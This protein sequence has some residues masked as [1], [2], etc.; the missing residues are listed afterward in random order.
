MNKSIE[1][2]V[3]RHE[4]VISTHEFIGKDGKDYKIKYYN[5]PGAPLDDSRHSLTDP[6]LVSAVEDIR[7]MIEE[8]FPNY[9]DEA[10]EGTLAK[11]DSFSR[12]AFAFSPEGKAVAF[13]LYKI[14][15]METNAG[16]AKVVYIEHAGTL[17]EYRSVGITQEMRNELFR[18]ENPDIICGSSANGVIYIVNK[19][20]AAEKN[21]AFYPTEETTP[22][23]ISRLANQI[24]DALGLR[25]AVLTDNLVRTYNDPTSRGDIEHPLGKS[26]PL[27]ETQ[28]IFYML[29]KPELRDSLLE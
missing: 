18:Q 23:A 12:F 29:I 20:I 6:S 3:P 11:F 8:I 28:H 16:N 9:E 25:N 5:F 15:G 7:K 14:S 21:M 26:L 1:T 17:P 4:P 2:G 22:I 27:K 24:H 10:V 19:K 13:N